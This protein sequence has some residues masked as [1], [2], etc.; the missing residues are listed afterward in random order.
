MSWYT[1]VCVT[2]LL[3][4]LTNQN[5]LPNYIYDNNISR[6]ERISNIDSYSSCLTKQYSWKNILLKHN[7]Y[8]W[9]LLQTEG[10]TI[11]EDFFYT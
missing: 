8:Q 4:Q 2:N 3:N 6:N 9:C 5:V 10:I 11:A 7:W 1:F